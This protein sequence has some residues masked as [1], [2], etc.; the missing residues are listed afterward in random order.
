MFPFADV[1]IIIM[2]IVF[3]FWF[4][5]LSRS[6]IKFFQLN[7]RYHV[8]SKTSCDFFPF[9]SAFLMHLASIYIWSSD[10][11]YQEEFV[12]YLG[13]CNP[14][15][16]D[17]QVQCHCMNSPIF[18]VG[19]CSRFLFVAAC[20]SSGFFGTQW[21]DYAWSLC[22]SW[23]FHGKRHW[24]AILS[25]PY[26]LLVVVMSSA[27]KHHQLF[28]WVTPSQYSFVICHLGWFLNLSSFI[29]QQPVCLFSSSYSDC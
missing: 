24:W 25:R 13:K 18:R 17:L 19:E 6:L 1:Y 27:G 8:I 16:Y 14:I 9:K 12:C 5:K 10:I 2:I 15:R 21:S 29:L 11:W 4:L 3:Q 26:I 7:G 20:F 22:R 28:V 23:L